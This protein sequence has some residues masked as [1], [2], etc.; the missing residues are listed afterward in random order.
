[1]QKQDHAPGEPCW[2]TLATTD[3]HAV[4]DLYQRLLG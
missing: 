1:M 3:P 2:V 4:A